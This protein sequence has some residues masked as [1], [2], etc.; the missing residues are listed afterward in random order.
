MAASTDSPFRSNESGAC[1][2]AAAEVL[3]AEESALG[4][5]I[6]DLLAEGVFAWTGPLMQGF[7]VADVLAEGAAFGVEGAVFTGGGVGVGSGEVG[8]EW[9]RKRRSHQD[10]REHRQW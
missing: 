7:P 5:E 4:L 3:L 6:G 2:G 1:F 9:R 10:V 8:A